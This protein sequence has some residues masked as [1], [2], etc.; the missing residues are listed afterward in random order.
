MNLY[1]FLTAGIDDDRH[2]PCFMVPGEDSISYGALAD[3]AGR[4]AAGLI[5]KGVVPGDRILLQ[6]HK[7]IESVMVY[8]GVLMV[9]AVI[10]PVNTSYTESEL[11]YFEE[12]AEPRLF[13]RNAAE[14][15]LECA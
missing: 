11:A 10:V 5:A 9:G 4:V 13:V 8:L 15:V 6:A 12:D 3:G 7:T 1:S 14:L 2:A